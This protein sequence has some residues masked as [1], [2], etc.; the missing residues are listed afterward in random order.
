MCSFIVP[1]ISF[2]DIIEDDKIEDNN[3]N[4]CDTMKQ[5]I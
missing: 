3:N 2:G 5:H 1:D 4:V